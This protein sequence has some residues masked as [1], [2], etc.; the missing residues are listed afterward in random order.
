MRILILTKRQYMRHDLLDERYGRFREIPL[1]LARLGHDI[2]GVCL[3]YRSREEGVI[4]DVEGDARVKWHSMNFRR[5]FS[6]GRGSYWRKVRQIGKDLQPDLIWACSDA[7]HAVIASRLASELDTCLVVDLYD[8]FESFG[9]CR[10]P[11]MKSAFRNALSRADAI[12][13]VS[14]PLSNYVRDTTSYKGPIEVIE[15]A[16]PK[17][18]FRP[19]G[20]S[21]C[22]RKLGLP[23]DSYVIGTAGAISKSRGIETLFQAFEIL[24]RERPDVRLA[25]AGPVDKGLSLPAGDHVHYL[26]MIPQIE[27]PTFLCSLDISVIC[28][29]DSAFGRYCFPQKFYESVAC[30]IPVVAAETGAMKEFLGDEPQCLF[31]P[32]NV[33]D[34]A[35]T[36]RSQIIRP[37]LLKWHVPTWDELGVRLESFFEDILH[38]SCYARNR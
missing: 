25:L 37:T 13:C 19:M 23:D 34:L 1:A 38:I 2:T 8:N 24:A 26:G 11:G 27:V 17:G 3:S 21:V 33:D 15:N 7:V 29:K 9:L 20:K 32:E 5:L 12:T 6:V 31:E 16:V 18:L 30:R 35:A 36:L 14:K 10:I 4:E 22:R 28:N